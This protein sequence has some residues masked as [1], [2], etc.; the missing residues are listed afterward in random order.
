MAVFC[1]LGQAAYFRRMKKICTL[2]FVAGVL[3]CNPT[4][5]KNADG[6]TT[7][8]KAAADMD[9]ERA[10]PKTTAVQHYQEKVNHD[11]NNWYFKV[12]LYETAKRFTYTIKLQYEEITG[13]DDI[14]LPNLGLEPQPI[15]KKGSAPYECIIGFMD[16]KNEFRE[17]KKVHIVD[18]ALKITTLKS[19]AVS[20]VQQ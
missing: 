5:T 1:L 18:G 12:D 4:D 7:T 3:A 16:E 14:T 13:E 10:S 9:L 15:L 6:S 2:F 17:Y 8:Q 20:T 19:Y 11:L